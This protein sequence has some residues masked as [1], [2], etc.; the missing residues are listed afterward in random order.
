MKKRQVFP[1]SAIV[2]QDKMKLGLV[3]NAINPKLSGVL[4]RGEKGT[5]KRTAIPV[6]LAVP[7]ISARAP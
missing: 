7:A 1:F 6:T 2:G 4:I 5:A 3:L